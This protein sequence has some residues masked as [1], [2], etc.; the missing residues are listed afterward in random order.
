MYGESL[1]QYN[2]PKATLINQA[3]NKVVVDSGTPQA[4]QYFGQGYTLMPAQTVPSSLNQSSISGGANITPYN[5]PDTMAAE[6]A[7]MDYGNT[8]ATQSVKDIA[9][10]TERSDKLYEQTQTSQS[11]LKNL[12]KT[13]GLESQDTETQLNA[14]GVNEN[15]KKL[16]DINAQIASWNT[17]FNK[18]SVDNEGRSVMTS[19][20]GGQ[21]SLIRRQQAVEVGA[22]T[23]MAQVLQGNISRA[24]QIV[25]KTMKM[26][27][28]PIRNQIDAEK[29]QLDMTYNDLSRADQKKADAQKTLLD[30]RSRLLSKQEKTETEVNNIAIASLD[31]G[32]DINTVNAIRNS[33]SMGEAIANSNNFLSGEKKIIADYMS[34]YADAG[35]T[36]KD[37][38]AQATAKLKNSKIYKEQVRP[39]VGSSNTSGLTKEQQAVV[40]DFDAA[41]VELASSKD[42]GK[43]WNTMKMKYPDMTNEEIDGA[44]GKDTFTK[45]N[46]GYFDKKSN[47][48]TSGFSNWWSQIPAKKAAGKSIFSTNY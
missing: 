6:K 13:L 47:P 29:A 26:K 34:K 28:D 10:Q 21:E 23:G 35:I 40:D 1:P 20:I 16:D 39:P 19:M 31:N 44:L 11:N 3:G 22:L 25:E 30:E 36:M 4:Q 27:Y 37:T 43:V 46:P 5:N 12:Y 17:A 14:L 18:A 15:N 41:R 7:T 32:A 2:M 38:L 8:L 24:Y 42:W 9:T 45:L 33:K 48:V